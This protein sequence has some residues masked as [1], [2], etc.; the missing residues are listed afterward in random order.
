MS[1]LKS[2]ADTGEILV[3]IRAACLVGIDD[4][5]RRRIA[6]YLIRQM[7]IGDDHIEAMI[8]CPFQRLKTSDTTIDTDDERNAVLLSM[9]E[10]RNID[11][12]ALGKAVWYVE[13]RI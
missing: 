7:M 8:A 12:V 3:G 13:N 9:F 10:S 1:E 4:G 2:D 6:A 11:A 5:Y